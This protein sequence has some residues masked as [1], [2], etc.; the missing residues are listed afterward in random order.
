MSEHQRV[1]LSRLRVALFGALLALGLAVQAA[2]LPPAD[3]F[4][5]NAVLGEAALSPDGRHLALSVGAKGSRARLAVL[6]LQ[7]MKPTVVAAFADADV[8]R[9][10]WVNDRRLVLDVVPTLTGPGLVE[11]GSGL[12][13]VNADGS[14]F[15]Q[16][17]ETRQS[18]V[19][20]S[21][22]AVPPLH[23]QTSLLQG[24]G[25]LDSDEVF[26][27]RPQEISRQKVDFFT[28]QRL[29]TNTGRAADVDAPPHS[30][31]WVP[32]AQGT[33]RLVVTR[34]ADQLAVRLRGA[35]GSWKAVAEFEMLS[36]RAIE[37]RWMAPDGR[38]YV[39]AQHQGTTALFTFDTAKGALSERPV[40]WVQG[41]DL[42]PSFV[43]TRGQ[44]LGLR[45][46]V[47][48]EV[49]QWLDPAMTALQARVDALLPAT[50]NRISLPLRGDSPFVLV[51]SWADV[52]PMLTSVYD[53]ATGKLARVGSSH[54]DID[55]RRMGMTDFVRYKARDGLD[56]PAYL[57]LPPGVPPR[58]LPLVVLVHGGPWVRGAQWQWDAEV[59]FLASRGY[60]VLQPEFRGSRGFGARL[61]EAGFGQ[62]GGTMQDDLADGARWAIARGTAD[63]RRICIAGASYGG[64][65]ALMGLAKDAGLFRCGISWVGVTDIQ[66]LFSSTWSDI[67][68]E[69]KRYGLGVMIGDPVAD[70]AKLTAASPLANAARI[71]QPLLL[72]Y[73]AFDTRVPVVHGERF[74]DA[75]KDHN[76]D[77]EWVV[78]GDEGHGWY[79]PETRIDFWGRVERFLA[80]HLAVP[81]DLP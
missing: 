71:R 72:A 55:P 29:D 76:P 64:Y 63:A 37:P 66:L 67:T 80:R 52:Q 32:D 50:A 13:A 27:V 28:L 41:F 14:G 19:K 74:R 61:F 4:F 22:Q 6:D 10:S 1:G 53:T 20:D 47:D 23:W 68:E 49:T 7:T 65:A 78:Y 2:G 42:H 62:W 26:V 8:G 44:L 40:A 11:F 73:G 38:L 25:A 43:V 31:R 56:I 15:R 34:Q 57:T 54:P 21:I 70:A 24:V 79:R 46:T 5:Q 58:Q 12:F 60:A 9:F 18:F 39:E 45:Y 75:V 35:D 3:A 77:V 36:P 48:G 33:L 69:G 59:Q 81:V 16:L 51:Q 30:V 17:V